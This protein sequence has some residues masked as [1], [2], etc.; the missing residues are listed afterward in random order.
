MEAAGIA[1]ASLTPQVVLLHDTCVEHG[2]Q[3]LHYVCRDAALGRSGFAA[4]WGERSGGVVRT[5]RG[6]PSTDSGVIPLSFRPV[7]P[8]FFDPLHERVSR[9]QSSATH[10][11]GY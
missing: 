4:G 1:P 11:P 5:G 2:C 3:W 6:R 9:C 8:G 10:D 7:W